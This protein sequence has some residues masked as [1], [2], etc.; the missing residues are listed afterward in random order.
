MICMSGPPAS[1]QGTLQ[2]TATHV[3]VTT[4]GSGATFEVKVSGTDGTVPSGTV[5]LW[6]GETPIAGAMLDGNGVA[7]YTANALPAGTR[8]VT[9]SYSGDAHFATSTSALAP[10][11]AAASGVPTF[12]LTA[13]P[14]TITVKAGTYGTTVISVIPANGFDQ[15]VTL[16]C[17]AL[18]IEA[19]CTFSPVNVLP[20][21][22]GATVIST[23]NIQTQAPSG[24]ATAWLQHDAGASPMLALVLP[25]AAV[26]AG[27]SLLRKRSRTVLR[28]LGVA[29]LLVGCSL[30][31]GSCAARYNYFHKPPSGNPGTTLGTS[32]ITITGAGVASSGTLVTATTQITLTVN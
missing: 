22:N 2:P 23:L 18:P 8:Q 5:S 29:I 13:N 25:G 12:T 20:G 10:V 31:L 21:T 27:I 26:L 14:P 17:S 15:S 3:A 7:T 24:T 9:A 19:T 28:V 6:S 1:A 32:T 11:A 4:G 30:G 16:S